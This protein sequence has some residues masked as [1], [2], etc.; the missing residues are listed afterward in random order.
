MRLAK[1]GKPGIYEGFDIEAYFADPCPR[2]SLSQS[3]AKIIL[4]K[5]P[6]HAMYAHPRLNKAVKDDEE[7]K[8]SG[9]QAIGSAAHKLILG[10]GKEIVVCSFD[11]WRKKAA[12]EARDEALAKGLVPILERQ[13]E[14]VEGLASIF[15][16]TMQAHDGLHW[17][18]AD[19]RSE[20]V[21]A[22]KESKFWFRSMIDAMTSDLLMIADLKTT[23][24]S[25]PPSEAGKKMAEDG[26]DIQAA[27]IDRG[28]AVLDPGNIGRRKYR[29]ISI[30][31]TPPFGIVVNELREG[32]LTLGRKKLDR[33]ADLWKRCLADKKWPCYPTV[34][35]Y[36]EHPP[37][38]VKEWEEREFAYLAGAV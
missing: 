19:L 31:Q 24:T 9:K 2:P 28:L 10:R 26:W 8:Y 6:A 22:W 17:N 23:A 5:S 15:R 20:I 30:E 14:Q 33:A 7:E 36:P 37:Y 34:I 1:I 35:N 4:E 16:A 29:F 12:Q 13:M 11:D 25:V 21:I 3:I 38:H 32:V 27:M 18:A